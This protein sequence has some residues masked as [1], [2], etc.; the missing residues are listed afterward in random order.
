MG[1]R[2]VRIGILDLIVLLC[3]R[4]AMDKT[5][6]EADILSEMISTNG[7]DFDPEGARALL[8]LRFTPEAIARMNELAEKNRLGTPFLAGKRGHGE[9]HAGRQLLEPHQSQ[10]SCVP[11]QAS[12][13]SP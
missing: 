11:V 6:T 9:I 3:Y 1:Y 10:S 4:E 7:G 12:T 13:R 2:D 5:L 8:A